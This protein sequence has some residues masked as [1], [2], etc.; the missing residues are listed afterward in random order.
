MY[1]TTSVILSGISPCFLGVVFG[2]RPF[3]CITL[4]KEWRTPMTQVAPPM[5]T[6]LQ[7]GLGLRCSIGHGPCGS[8]GTARSQ[9]FWETGAW[10]APGFV[11]VLGDQR[12]STK[13]WYAGSNS[14]D[15]GNLRSGSCFFSGKSQGFW[16]NLRGLETCKQPGR[17][18][19]TRLLGKPRSWETCKQPHSNRTQPSTRQPD[20]LPAQGP[21][22]HVLHAPRSSRTDPFSR[23]RR[24][25][26]ASQETE[27]GNGLDEVRKLV[28]PSQETGWV[29][30]RN[31]WMRCC[32]S[33]NGPG[34]DRHNASESCER[35]G[36]K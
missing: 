14:D 34:N 24:H 11:V 17:N 20:R 19:F 3:C 13:D 36:V 21:G 16:G 9:G 10:K 23:S 30:S 2:V 18:P 5:W 27:S 12:H 7:S 32:E 6:L 35:F 8:G 25:S 31:M 33:G 22:N 29:V 4:P 1:S 26:G 28:G 15:S